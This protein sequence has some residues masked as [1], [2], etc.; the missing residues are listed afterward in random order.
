MAY[1]FQV[2]AAIL[3]GSVTH[4]ELATFNSGLGANEQNIVNVG[5]IRLD[6]IQAD[7][8]EIDIELADNQANALEIKES[9][10]VYM[11]F[12]STNSAEGIY[13]L[14]PMLFPDDTP[15][16]FGSAVGGDASIEFVNAGSAEVLQISAPANG[17]VIA[18]TTPTLVIGD[19]QDEDTKLVF[20]Q[21]GQDFYVG[22][23]ATDDDLKIG[24]GSAVGTNTAITLNGDAN[25][26]MAGD[27]T[28]A[29]NLV[30]NGTTTAINSTTIEITSSFTF[31]GATPDGNETV[32][33]VVDPTA[34][35]AINLADSAGTLVPFAAV[36]AAGTQIT[37]TPTELNLLDAITRGSILHGNASGASARLAAGGAN[38]VLS[39]D[40][41][42]ISYTAVSNAM[43]AGSIDD[44]KL[45]QLTTA[46]KVALSALEIDGATDIGEDLV[47]ADLLIVDNGADGTNRKVAMSRIRT[48]IGGGTVPVA[49][50]GDSDGQSLSVGVNVASANTSAPRSLSLP[51]SSGLSVGQSI[52]V[53][54]AGVS[55]G[56]VTIAR[57]GSQTID[58]NLTS[59]VLESDNAAI[60][61]VYV[62]ADDWRIF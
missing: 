54:V 59:V 13:S 5:N 48:Y 27:L 39:S 60:E 62:A 45:N 46:G 58:G 34:D 40:G 49:T 25:V 7:G 17:V 44:S 16:A 32:L 14:K 12:D 3:S 47:D 51:A 29:G 23:D 11:R 21:S 9:S 36:P 8:N 37:S 31:E 18:G 33:G 22:V 1:K 24:L 56:A 43:L 15:L 42:D 2:G 4:K 53:K 41:T 38:T 50:F 6:T 55:S 61:L 26:T 35:R 30:I 20:D 28:V 19:N 10:N 52:R 57:N